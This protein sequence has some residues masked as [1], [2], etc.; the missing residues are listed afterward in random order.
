[1]DALFFVRICR[2]DFVR[3]SHFGAKSQVFLNRRSEV[4][5]L[6]GPPVNQAFIE[7]GRLASGHG[8]NAGVNKNKQK[9]CGQRPDR[10]P[11]RGQRRPD[12]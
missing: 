6:S 5:L 4:R 11:A 12:A 8:V 1:M 10:P 7:L 9:R 3:P 2:I